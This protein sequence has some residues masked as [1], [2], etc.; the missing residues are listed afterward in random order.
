MV[1]SRVTKNSKSRSKSN[2][3]TN[4]KQRGGMYSM[5]QVQD[6]V[7][8]VI[9]N[10]PMTLEEI[11]QLK[12]FLDLTREER[13]SFNLEDR[14]ILEQ[15]EAALEAPIQ[16]LQ[17]L[18]QLPIQHLENHE[19]DVFIK[20]VL[21]SYIQNSMLFVQSLSGEIQY[22]DGYTDFLKHT[23]EENLFKLLNYIQ[24]LSLEEQYYKFNNEG[25]LKRLTRERVSDFDFVLS[26]GAGFK[27]LGFIM[28]RILL[29][30]SELDINKVVETMSEYF[31]N[32]IIN[33]QEFNDDNKVKT[34]FTIF[35]GIFTLILESVVHVMAVVQ[36]FNKL[37]EKNDP[38]IKRGTDW[39]KY[40]DNVSKN[41]GQAIFFQSLFPSDR[42]DIINKL[43][44]MF[45]TPVPDGLETENSFIQLESSYN[46]ICYSRKVDCSISNETDK[47]KKIQEIIVEAGKFLDNYRKV[48]CSYDRDEAVKNLRGFFP[49]EEKDYKERFYEF[50]E[51]AFSFKQVTTI[52][53]L[54][55]KIKVNL[56]D[57]QN[58]DVLGGGARKSKKQKRKS[59]NSK[60]RKSNKSKK[61]SRN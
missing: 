33:N 42:K 21:K 44:R 61:N 52:D 14:E 24:I 37:V 5:E 29:K 25:N 9:N 16:L 18:E 2:T 60:K 41:L 32:G 49:E 1:K 13:F 3:R 59:N 51:F 58:I 15:V 28:P 23:N 34:F 8:K 19:R 20:S 7:G 27:T 40:F 11:Q 26:S 4:K 53:K 22:V 56:R 45:P 55:E 50:F 17:N 35:A 46:K 57:K 36:Y 12:N 48:C 54:L 30:Y 31:A 43:Y 6:L 47:Q 38:L 10:E 39:R